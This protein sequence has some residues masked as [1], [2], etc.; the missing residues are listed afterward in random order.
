MSNTEITQGR[1]SLGTL[2][3]ILEAKRERGDPTEECDFFIS[4]AKRHA[5]SLN[6]STSTALFYERRAV[7]SG[8]HFGDELAARERFLTM[9]EEFR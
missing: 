4:R 7:Q 2:Y 9:I 5:F 3:A 6:T 8:S 1:R